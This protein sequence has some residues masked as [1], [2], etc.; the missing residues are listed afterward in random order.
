MREREG[1]PVENWLQCLVSL[2]SEQMTLE[3]YASP[4]LHGE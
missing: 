1:V 4:L 2:C 3:G